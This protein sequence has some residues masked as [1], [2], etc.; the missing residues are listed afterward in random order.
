LETA[1][2]AI[3]AHNTTATGTELVSYISEGFG[4]STFVREDD[5]VYHTYSTTDRGVE[6][7]MGYYGILG[8]A[9]KGRNE[10]DEWQVWIRRHDEYDIE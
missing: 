6:F 1:L 2:S 9:P 7:L 10:D 4:F 5:T 3:A 8:R